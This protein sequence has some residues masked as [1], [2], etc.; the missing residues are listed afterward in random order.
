MVCNFFCHAVTPASP[1]ALPKVS[2]QVERVPSSTHNH[3][4]ALQERW[5]QGSRWAR[6]SGGWSRVAGR[7]EVGQTGWVHWG[8]QL[9][10]CYMLPTRS[11]LSTQ[12]QDLLWTSRKIP[13]RMILV[14]FGCPRHWCVV[15]GSGLRASL[16]LLHLPLLGARK[17]GTQSLAPTLT[18]PISEKTQAYK[19]WFTLGLWWHCR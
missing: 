11:K 3:R 4:K 14:G 13:F 16:P 19:V 9:R 12:C 2:V 6:D 8:C 1:L 7:R 5:R 17:A 15:A 18:L 10:M